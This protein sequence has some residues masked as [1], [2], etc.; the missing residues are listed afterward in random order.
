VPIDMMT[1]EKEDKAL[2]MLDVM[3]RGTSI[4]AIEKKRTNKSL[5]VMETMIMP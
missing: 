1:M 2:A 4:S 5:I 3:R